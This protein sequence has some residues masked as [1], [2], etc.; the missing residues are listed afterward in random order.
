[1]EVARQEAAALQEAYSHGTPSGG[2]TPDEI[3]AQVGK[4]QDIPTYGAA[5]VAT[6][7][8]EGLLTMTLDA[9]TMD[10]SP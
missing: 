6:A 2:R 9:T 10:D 4:H 1:M 8:T 3:L 7:G 5:F